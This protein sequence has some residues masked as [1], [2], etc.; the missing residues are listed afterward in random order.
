MARGT[1]LD[2]RE[3]VPDAV[4]E[5]K[6]REKERFDKGHEASEDLWNGRG[7]KANGKELIR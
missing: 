2:L 5:D 3:T 1:E 6:G 4:M 7:G